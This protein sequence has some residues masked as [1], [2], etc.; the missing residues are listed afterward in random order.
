MRTI[1]IL[2]AEDND[3]DAAIIVLAL[4]EYPLTHVLSRAS[5]GEQAIHMIE[6][7]GEPNGSPCPDIFLLDLNM[8]KACGAEV[9][10]VFRNH[11]GCRKV[12]VIIVSSSYSS[13]DKQQMAELGISSYFV[14]PMD[15]DEYMKLGE[16]V[17]NIAA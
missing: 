5:D 2:L 16:M 4:Q 13:K 11:A 15:L 6:E 10:K 1:H 17:A 9:L 3:A 12:P 7:L 14:K 8:P